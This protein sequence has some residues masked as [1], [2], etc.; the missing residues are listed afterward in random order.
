[1]MHALASQIIFE[2]DSDFEVKCFQVGV[3]IQRR[4]ANSKQS[5]VKSVR[6]YSR[7]PNLSSNAAPL[8]FYN[9]N[10]FEWRSFEAH[11]ANVRVLDLP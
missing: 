2:K 3:P 5:T 9:E 7:L 4:A 1:M 6:V 8:D 11:L 10:K